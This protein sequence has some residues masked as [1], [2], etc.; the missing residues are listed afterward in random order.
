MRV[1]V[2]MSPC[3]SY[4]NMLNEWNPIFLGISRIASYWIISQTGAA[5]GFSSIVELLGLYEKPDI[6]Q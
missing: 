6:S 2:S 4:E 1:A 3:L 5:E